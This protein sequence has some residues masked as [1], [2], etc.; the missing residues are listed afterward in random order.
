MV[1]MALPDDVAVKVCGFSTEE[2]LVT[3]SWISEC[4]PIEGGR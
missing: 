1:D 3:T 4:V 2:Q